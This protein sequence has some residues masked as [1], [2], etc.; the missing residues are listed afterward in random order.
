ME[1]REHGFS[2]YLNGANLTQRQKPVLHDSAQNP[3]PGGLEPIISGSCEPLSVRTRPSRTAGTNRNF[4]VYAVH[5]VL[6]IFTLVA[7]F[8]ECL[9]RALL[10]Q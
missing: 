6:K 2:L 10:I 3:G 8:H 4:R 1:K 7:L 9:L 5:C